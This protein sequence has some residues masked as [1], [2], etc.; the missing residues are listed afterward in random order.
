VLLFLATATASAGPLKDGDPAP[1][2]ELKDLEGK[3]K[4]LKEVRAGKS[5][6]LCFWATWWSPPCSGEGGCCAP[7]TKHA[8]SA[9]LLA[10]LEDL[11]KWYPPR[12]L[13]LCVIAIDKNEGAVRKMVAEVKPS[14]L[15]VLD[16]SLK[17]ARAYGIKALPTVFLI[18]PH[19]IIQY[20]DGELLLNRGKDKK[21]LESV[22]ARL[23]KP[24][25]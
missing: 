1:V 21:A 6:L 4:S 12:E 9:V 24:S 23:V 18:D 3:P 11:R 16:P 25:G 13:E 22:L 17:V 15:V 5:L 8:S 14:V 7:G 20:Q 19:G 2:F 10:Y